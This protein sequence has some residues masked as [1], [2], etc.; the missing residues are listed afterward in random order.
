MRECGLDAH[1]HE[2]QRAEGVST[3]ERQGKG[4]SK[5]SLILVSTSYFRYAMLVHASS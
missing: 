4:A 1:R 5:G 2:L 3:A